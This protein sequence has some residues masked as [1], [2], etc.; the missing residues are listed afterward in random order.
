MT[1]AI[2]NQRGNCLDL[3]AKTIARSTVNA[4]SIA[5]PN[6]LNRPTSPSKLYA[7]N[8]IL[9]TGNYAATAKATVGRQ[10]P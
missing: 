2:L 6:P 4:T 10:P 9:S 8:G 3:S 1:S 7:A 5:Y